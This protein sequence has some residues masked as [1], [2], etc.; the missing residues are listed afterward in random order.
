MQ[1]Y[2]VYFQISQSKNLNFLLFIRIVYTY[3][4][5]RF[6]RGASVGD[7]IE[8]LGESNRDTIV[9]CVLFLE[10]YGF[11]TYVHSTC[12]M[13]HYVADVFQNPHLIKRTCDKTI[14]PP[15]DPQL[16]TAATGGTERKPTQYY[17]MVRPHYWVRIDGEVSKDLINTL[18]NTI[19]SVL[20]DRQGIEFLELAD[21]LPSVPLDDIAMILDLM[22][23][24]EV[25]YT[26]YMQSKSLFEQLNGES[27]EDEDVFCE[28]NDVCVAPI[29][30][31]EFLIEIAKYIENPSENERTRR[32]VFLSPSAFLS[33][34]LLLDSTVPE[35]ISAFL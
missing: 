8:H 7:L 31:T 15:D 12:A 6:I 2:V 13:P 21:Q 35:Q 32:Y 27:N 20:N 29:T 24:D 23:S 4:L 16:P 9:K 25:V 18:R 28:E 5:M 19:C 30:N 33:E 3:I 17:D 10:E 11:I 22:E 34:S 1:T 14:Y 26:R